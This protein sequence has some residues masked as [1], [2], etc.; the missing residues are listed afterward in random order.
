MNV[1]GSCTDPNPEQHQREY[2]FLYDV[3]ETYLMRYTDYFVEDLIA[4][5]T[6]AYDGEF[7]PP[8]IIACR[9]I[10]MWYKRSIINSMLSERLIMTSR[11]TGM[12]IHK[13]HLL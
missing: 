9:F 13:I 2:E 6:A 11:E 8:D 4:V 1:H 7:K 12:H 5:M 3:V 10:I